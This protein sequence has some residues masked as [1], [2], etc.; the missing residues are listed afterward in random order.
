MFKVIAGA[1]LAACVLCAGSAGAQS[2]ELKP[3]RLM[4]QTTAFGAPILVA[5]DKGWYEEALNKVGYTL[6]ISTATFGPPVLEAMAAGQIDIGELGASPFVVG[7]ARGLP[8]KAVL[9][10]NI[11]G[12]SIMVHR[13]SPIKSIKDLAGKKIAINGKGTMM[14]FIVRRALAANGVKSGDVTWVELSAPDSST[15]LDRNQIDAA[16]L[17]EPW[18]AR[19]QL[20]GHRMIATGQEIWPNHDNQLITATTAAIRDHEPAVRAFIEQTIR[21]I[22]YIMDNPEDS[23]TITARRLGIERDIIARSWPNMIRRRSGAPNA[24]GLQEFINALREWNYVKTPVTAKDGI[25]T[26]FLK[27]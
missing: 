5:I 10:T 17:F 14:D 15:A 25:D 9:A 24:E 19:L 27:N 26:R 20:Q 23:I 8:I 1:L 21:G 11:S 3:I 22:A 12:E 2:R 16:A 13:D 6:K 4:Y 7:F 18:T